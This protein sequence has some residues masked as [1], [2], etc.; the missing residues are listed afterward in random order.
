MA[1]QLKLCFDFFWDQFHIGAAEINK[2]TSNVIIKKFLDINL[3]L[4]LLYKS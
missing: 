3:F 2:I 4:E 1:P